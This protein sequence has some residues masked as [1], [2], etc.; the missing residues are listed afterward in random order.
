MS[1]TTIP[2]YTRVAIWEAHDRRCIYCSETISFNE[3]E[4]DHIVPEHLFEKP[5]R[6]LEILKE[7]DLPSDF[8]RSEPYNLL[9]CHRR[10]NAR[11]SGTAFKKSTALYYLSLAEKKISTVEKVIKRLVRQANTD[12]ILT[13]LQIALELGEL[14]SKQV[15]DLVKRIETS[16]DAIEILSS[17]EFS[18]QIIRGI[19]KREDIDKL[20]TEPI[21]P[22][23]HGLDYITMV[24]DQEDRTDILTVTSCREWEDAIKSGYLPRSNYDIKEEAFFKK[25]YA[26]LTAISV[27]HT[28]DKN[29][30]DAPLVGI[31]NI[32]LLP[33]TM[34]PYLSRE[35]ETEIKAMND[36]GVTIADLVS[37][38]KVIIEEQ[39]RYY[40]RSW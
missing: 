15:Y 36:R 38:K 4:I 20:L 24:R 7:Y 40:I 31:Q 2:T 32:E 37:E 18:N 16:E 22:R 30:I 35:E 13:S 29:Y 19:L 6:L 8:P 12:R 17:L 28:A 5:E 1:F 10:C 3:L 11:K 34:L 25:I 21:L 39:S 9:P 33:V 14:S 27:A 26:T 23:M